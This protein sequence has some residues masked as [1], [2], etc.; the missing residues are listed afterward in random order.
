MKGLGLHG[1]H[2]LNTRAKH[3]AS[4]LTEC[5]QRHGGIVLEIPLISIEKPVDCTP[6]YRVIQQLGRYDWIVFTSA[7]SVHFFMEFLTNEGKRV[8]ELQRKKIAVVGNKTLKYLQKKGITPQVVPSTFSGEYLTEELLK[9]IKLGER[10]LFPR[11]SLSSNYL[12]H[13][14]QQKD[15]EVDAPIVYETA[16]NTSIKK[17]LHD[18]LLTE[19]IDIITFT[20]P[21]TVRSFF[22]QIDQSLIENNRLDSILFAVIGTVTAKELKEYGVKEMIIPKQF[23]IEGLVEELL[24]KQ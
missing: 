6:V 3:Q 15:M 9:N 14:L 21:S 12:V 1:R 17:E 18:T 7:N 5:L 13:T 22:M 4:E 24:E 2:I 16:M 20:S 19:K 11:S 8:E 10:I 23:T